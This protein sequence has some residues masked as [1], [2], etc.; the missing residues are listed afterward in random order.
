MTVSAKSESLRSLIQP[1]ITGAALY[2]ENKAA[3]EGDWTRKGEIDAMNHTRQQE[4][5]DF[6]SE[7]H[8]LLNHHF[9]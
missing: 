2:S 8:V 1:L 7:S 3:E 6:F 5:F 4:K 9:L